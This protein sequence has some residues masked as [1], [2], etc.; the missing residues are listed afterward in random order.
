[1]KFRDRTFDQGDQ[2]RK[3]HDKAEVHRLEENRISLG[4]GRSHFGEG[5]GQR[6]PVA[7]IVSKGVAPLDREPAD[8]VR[9]GVAPT[10]QDVWLRWYHMTRPSRPVRSHRCEDLDDSALLLASLPPCLLKAKSAQ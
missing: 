7:H 4:N 6:I 1:M 5:R 8:A 9:E 3:G 2:S 10:S